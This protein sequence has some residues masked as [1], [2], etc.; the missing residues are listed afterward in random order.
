MAV[1]LGGIVGEGA[2]D[3][4]GDIGVISTTSLT[5]GVCV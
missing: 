1:M 2:G 5:L 3:F 4:K